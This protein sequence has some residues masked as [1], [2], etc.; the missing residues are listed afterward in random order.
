MQQNLRFSTVSSVKKLSIGKRELVY[1]IFLHAKSINR[2]N[3]LDL[4]FFMI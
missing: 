2:V 1:L 4:L 3:F